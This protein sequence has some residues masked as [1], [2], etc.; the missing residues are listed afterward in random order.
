MMRASAPTVRRSVPALAVSLAIPL[1]LSLAGCQRETT[2]AVEPPSAPSQQTEVAQAA[3]PPAEAG[4]ADRRAAELGQNPRTVVIPPEP[5][6]SPPSPRRE[7]LEAREKRL[8][9]RQAELDRRE[10]SLRQR[11]EE[12]APSAPA[13]APPTPDH[14]A[15][16]PAPEPEPAP[17]PEPAQVT[18]DLPAGTTFNVELSKGLSSA[19]SR[20]GE[21]FR[22]RITG[23][24]TR[25]GEVAIPAG[26]E[27][28]GEVTQAVPLKQIGGQASLGIRFTD[29]VLPTGETIP[30]QAS[31]LREGK[32]ESK[33]AAATIG[34]AA[35]GGAILGNILSRG[36]RGGGSVI[37]ALIGAVA[38][39]A[40]AA[41]HKGQE[42]EIP[43]GTVLG[44][45]L[46]QAVEVRS[47][48]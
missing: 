19:T 8:A 18:V 1:A 24:V 22:A 47:R 5:P 23:N 6:P 46:D 11:E 44:L 43:P 10:R 16:A 9:A 7:S 48:Q 37:G 15:A 25:D 14:E 41:H 45:Q 27:V 2:R 26:S 29:L 38:G 20:A 34:G 42:V 4:G 40:I 36:N 31:L 21:T 28:V 35:A 33:R 39:T 3:P 13:P 30:I 12:T 32:N 17:A